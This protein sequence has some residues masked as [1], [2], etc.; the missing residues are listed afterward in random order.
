MNKQEAAEYLGIGM[1]SLE[2]YMA[3]GRVA[4]SRQ[5][6]K[7]GE[8]VVF[9]EAELKRFKDELYEPIHQGAIEVGRVL[10]VD[11]SATQREVLVEIGENLRN[12]CESMDSMLEEIKEL[13][14]EVPV[15]TKSL[16]SLAEAQRFSGLSRQ[17]LLQAIREGRLCGGKIGKGWRVRRRDLDRFISKLFLEW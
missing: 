4:F 12:I 15:H 8:K 3:Q 17:F 13:R 16:L 1:R 5:R 9:A 7:T 14:S 6:I 2:R 10:P 11:N